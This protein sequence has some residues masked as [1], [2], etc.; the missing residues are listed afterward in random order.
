MVMFHMSSKLRVV[1]VERF[2][3]QLAIRQLFCALQRSYTKSNHVVGAPPAR[4]YGRP[5][6]IAG[7]ESASSFG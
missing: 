3:G 4:T 1:G 7:L 2:T 5:E 6:A